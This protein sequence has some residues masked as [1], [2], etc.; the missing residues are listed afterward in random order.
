MYNKKTHLNLSHL[1]FWS[2][3]PLSLSLAFCHISTVLSRKCKDAKKSIFLYF[4]DQLLNSSVIKNLLDRYHY[5]IDDLKWLQFK[6]DMLL[7]K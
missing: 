3:P 2:H 6:V 1:P 5:N 7:D 4:T